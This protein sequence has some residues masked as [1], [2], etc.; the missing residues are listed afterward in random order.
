MAAATKP[1]V[2]LL[3]RRGAVGI[4]GFRAR[5]AGKRDW[6][7][8]LASDLMRNRVQ[9]VLGNESDARILRNAEQVR[10]ALLKWKDK[11]GAVSVPN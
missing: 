2:D 7:L 6:A 3:L 10:A 4:V 5:A 9:W 1:G 11:P 8:A